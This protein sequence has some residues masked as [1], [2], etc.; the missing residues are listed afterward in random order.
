ME[1]AGSLPVSGFLLVGL[2]AKAPGPRICQGLFPQLC[3]PWDPSKGSS[4]P[5]IEITQAE[6]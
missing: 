6:E 4:R 5:L 3:H 2:E 1:A